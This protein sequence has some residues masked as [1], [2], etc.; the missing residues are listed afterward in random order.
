MTIRNSAVTIGID[1][2]SSVESSADASFSAPRQS[3]SIPLTDQE[4]KYFCPTPPTVKHWGEE[5]VVFH[6]GSSNTFL[7]DEFAAILIAQLSEGPRTLAQLRQFISASY[8]LEN[9][10]S[11]ET[12]LG[13]KI[14]ELMRLDFVETQQPCS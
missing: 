4:M 14:D 8:E 6:P 10:T 5:A 12:A 3:D 1:A 2:H 11:L 13:Q 7:L 9:E